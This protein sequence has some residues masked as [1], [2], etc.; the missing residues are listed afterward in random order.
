M[1]NSAK[2]FSLLTDQVSHLVVKCSV[3]LK[4]LK[5][6]NNSFFVIL[7]TCYQGYYCPDTEIVSPRR[8]PIGT[9]SL[10]KNATS[11]TDC[12]SCPK[13]ES[14]REHWKKR[15]GPKTVTM[16]QTNC[17]STSRAQGKSYIWIFFILVLRPFMQ[18]L[19]L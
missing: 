7:V 3:N 18:L 13:D 12:L 8:C 15:M 10:Y 14:E 5:L 4:S 1:T 2:S 17:Y 19:S 16:F 9:F 11:I 6:I